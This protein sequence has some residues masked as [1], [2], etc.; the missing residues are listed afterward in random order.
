[1]SGPQE[2]CSACTLGQA[3][4]GAGC[5]FEEVRRPPGSTVLSQGE[6]PSHA[7]YLRE[8]RVL[9]TAVD[10]DGNERTCAVREPGAFLGFE[11]LRGRPSRHDAKT[12]SN[13]VFCRLDET[14]LRT[15]LGERLTPASALLGF[16][17]DETDQ[18][19]EEGRLR[20]GRAS[21]RL[22]RYLAGRAARSGTLLPVPRH[23]LARLLGLRPETLSRALRRL[24]DRGALE[25]GHEI[26][27][28]DLERL[29]AESAGTDPGT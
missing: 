27:I 1:M 13:S 3:S 28:R 9:L 17:L 29:E 18:E 12:L 19:N 7:W 8:G 5:P 20:A 16:A 2:I 21:A 14:R 22:A 26:A 11:A 25:E 24:R 6:V 4:N 15:W 10:A 23:F